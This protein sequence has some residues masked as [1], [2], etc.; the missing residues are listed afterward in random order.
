M[1]QSDYDSPW[2]DALYFLFDSF[3]ALFFPLRACTDRLVARL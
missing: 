1:E 3:I 2:K